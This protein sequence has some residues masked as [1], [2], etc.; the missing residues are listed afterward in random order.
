MREPDNRF[1]DTYFAKRSLNDDRRRK[2]FKSEK[3][4]LQKYVDF[5]GTIC[6]VGCSTGEFLTSIGW[7][8]PKYGMEINQY[9]INMAKKSGIS[10]DK[11]IKTIENFFDVVVFRGTIQLLPDPFRYIMYAHKAIRKGGVICFLATPNANCIVYKL[12]NTLPAL[13]PKLNFFMPSDIVLNQI[14]DNCGFNIVEVEKPYL[15]SPYA[16]P[17][18]DHLLFVASL[19]GLRKPNFPFWGNMTNLIAVKR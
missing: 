2:S 3:S 12:F 19:V 8:G 9:A 13:E 14:L 16:M 10:F 18:R 5:E 7:T 11:N 4:L 17:L 15:N 6:D 1:P